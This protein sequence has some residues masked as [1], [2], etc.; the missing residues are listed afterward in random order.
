MRTPARIATFAV[1]VGLTFGA[2]ALVGA[3]LDPLRDAEDSHGHEAE[4]SAAHGGGHGEASEADAAE[5]PVGLAV[6]QNGYR[7]EPE[8]S[9][10]PLGRE[11]EIAF[12]ITGPD[13]AAV[14]DFDVEHERRDAPDRGAP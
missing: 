4:P 10:L 7:L 11:A 2:A 1:A 5:Q 12:R 9:A 3:A 14:T 13:G 8:A 6:A